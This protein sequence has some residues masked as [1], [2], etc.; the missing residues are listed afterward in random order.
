MKQLPFGEF[1]FSEIITENK[2]YADKTGYIYDLLKGEEGKSF[3]LSRP[4]RFGKTLLIHTLKDLFLGNHQY[5]NGLLIDKLGYDF[6]K[7][8]VIL[9]SFFYSAETSEELKIALTD[10]LNEIAGY[11]NIVIDEKIKNIPDLYFRALIV[12]LSKKADSR[13]VVLVDEYDAPVTKNMGNLDLA[14]ANAKILSDFFSVLKRP[15]VSERLRFTFVTG[16]TRYA[17]TSMDSGPN[18]LYDLSLEP[19]YAG[20]CGF[21]L[22]EFDLLF[23]D[24]MEGLLPKVISLGGLPSGASL[25]D[26]K[27]K[28]FEWYDGYN[29][30]GDTRVLNPYS[31]IYFFNKAIFSNYWIKSGRPGHLTALIKERPFDFLAPRLNDYTSETIIKSTMTQLQP[32]PVL[33]HSGYLTLDN[34]SGDNL[35]FRTPN[36]EVS[37]S[38][39]KDCFEIIFQENK[40]IQFATKAEELNIAFFEKNSQAV[41]KIFK[42]LFSSISYYN[43]PSSESAYHSIIKSILT[44][45][46]F[47]VF[48]ELA[49]NTGRSDLTIELE[50]GIYLIIEIKYCANIM[51]YTEKEVQ[52]ILA[53]KARVTFTQ[54]MKNEFYINALANKL[55]PHDF[56]MLLI[57]EGLSSLTAEKRTTALGKIALGYLDDKDLDSIL[58]EM[59]KKYL[60]EEM[61]SDILGSSN[62]EFDYSEEKIDTILTTAA[63]TGLDNIIKL[64]YHGPV[65]YRAKRIID[66][67]LAIY[68]YGT[69]VKAIFG[70]D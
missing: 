46:K 25:A 52:K 4:R 24:R 54:E 48:S 20:I 60:S 50:D 34:I 57:N 27:S 59:S 64:N 67:G 43:R 41:S 68:G 15:G 8:P 39:L 26:L 19:K 11:Y 62:I 6:P 28:I 14:Q 3:F 22:E 9:L 55:K 13:V 21:T 12:A 18:H 31:L 63:K 66:L 65:K 53:D 10:N 16:I 5:F 7:Y 45:S 33:F 23:A 36:F 42:D 51:K 70:P 69:H 61:I 44:F 56:E 40:G 30:G 35:T 38:Y 2:L 58:A 37:N 1:T 32:V 47:K 49:S 17:L 29:W